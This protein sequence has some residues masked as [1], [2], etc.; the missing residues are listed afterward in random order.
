MRDSFTTGLV[1]DD[2]FSMLVDRACY[3][4]KRF[5]VG[6]DPAAITRLIERALLAGGRREKGKTERGTWRREGYGEQGNE[7]REGEGGAEEK[8]G[9]RSGT[10]NRVKSD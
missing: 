1:V 4:H 10:V 6:P 7:E 3:A 2:H 5:E 8:Y 9:E